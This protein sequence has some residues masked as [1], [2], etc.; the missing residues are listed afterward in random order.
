MQ[1]QNDTHKKQKKKIEIEK[2]WKI[3]VLFII[4]NKKIDFN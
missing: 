2:T 3:Y 4:T 1:K